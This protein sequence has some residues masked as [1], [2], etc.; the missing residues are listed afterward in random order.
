M[1]DISLAE[2]LFQLLKLRRAKISV[3]ESFTG[4][5]IPK[6]FVEFGVI[7]VFTW[8]GLNTYTH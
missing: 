1:D 7:C 2:R 5:V 4:G 6:K 3:A 8:G